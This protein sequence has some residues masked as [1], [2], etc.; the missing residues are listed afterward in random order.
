MASVRMSKGPKDGSCWIFVG[1]VELKLS[2]V[3]GDK[4]PLCTG[5][6]RE[7]RGDLEVSHD[8]LMRAKKMAASAFKKAKRQAESTEQGVLF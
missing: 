1:N 7:G 3:G 5:K 2:E 8:L 6:R 4:L